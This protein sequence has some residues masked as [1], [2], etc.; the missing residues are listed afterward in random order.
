MNIESSSTN[1][2]FSDLP[3][4]Y[5]A[6]TAHS[7]AKISAANGIALL[8]AVKNG[9]EDDA[10]VLIREVDECQFHRRGAITLH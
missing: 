2:L 8:F 7:V 3:G 5:N 1:D 6:P 10:S 4:G 9:Q